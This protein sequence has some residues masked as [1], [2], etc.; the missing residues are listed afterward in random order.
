MVPSM[1]VGPCGGKS[2]ILAHMQKVLPGMG[3][4]VVSVPEASTMIVT[5]GG[6]YPGMSEEKR[7]LL[8]EYETVLV[9]LQ[10]QLEET[11]VALAEYYRK[12]GDNVVVVY[13]RGML[14]VKAYAPADIW[15]ALL[16]EFHQTEEELLAR[17]DIVVHLV[18]AADGAEAFY[19]S[20]NNAARIETAD[21][22]KELD[23]RTFNCWKGH[24][25]LHRV[26]NKS[27]ENAF[28]VKINDTL[29]VLNS[30][31]TSR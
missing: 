31:V 7:G 24:S 10:L 20:A 21:Q 27:V 29:Q 3:F 30:F 23:T 15:Q 19:T 13:D 9:R 6:Q 2:S 16:A 26:E 12:Q 1:Y 18:T 25:Q 11:F 22:A 8:L 5:N 17:Y 4:K 28:S 14:D